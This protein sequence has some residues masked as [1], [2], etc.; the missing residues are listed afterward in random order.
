VPGRK[1]TGWVPRD[2]LVQL[3]LFGQDEAG[4]VVRHVVETKESADSRRH[5]KQEDAVR[6]KGEHPIT[7]GPLHPEAERKF[8]TS[9]KAA[10]TCGTCLFRRQVG[11]SMKCTNFDERYATDSV[12]TNV[13]AEFPA[14]PGYERFGS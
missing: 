13:L 5:R 3:D 10:F 7:H 14:C 9:G 1:E 4:P 8:A 2:G 6:D 11:K 12:I